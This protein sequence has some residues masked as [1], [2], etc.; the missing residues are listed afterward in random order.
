MSRAPMVRAVIALAIIGASLYAALTVPAKLG[1]DLKGGTQI[2]LETKDGP[3]TEANQETT[4]RTIEVLNRRVNELGLTEPNLTRSGENR[5]IVELPGL[6]DPRK[7]VEVIGRTAQLSF[8][9]VRTVVPEGEKPQPKKG[10]RVLK[11]ESGQ[12]LLLGPAELTG[13]DVKGATSALDPQTNTQWVV[14]VEFA[15]QGSGFG[16]FGSSTPDS[17]S[18][19]L[20]A[21]SHDPSSTDLLTDS[22]RNLHSSVSPFL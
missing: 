16:G 7:A 11:D 9:P 3:R 20:N 10:E 6:Q 18:V 22:F 8:H 2:V 14:D 21:F 12:Q 15:G 13:D 17:P 4:D 1:L 5:I 19:D